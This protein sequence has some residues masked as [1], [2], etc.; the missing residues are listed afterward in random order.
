MDPTIANEQMLH[1][2]FD[3]RVHHVIA[4]ND[5]KQKNVFDELQS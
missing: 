2:A 4:I 3:M 5:Y 1:H